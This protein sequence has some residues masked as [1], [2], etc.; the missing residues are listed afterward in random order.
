[1][2]YRLGLQLSVIQWLHFELYIVRSKGLMRVKISR[3]GARS[4]PELVLV[5]AMDSTKPQRL[6]LGQRT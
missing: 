4:V 1:M 5:A 6:R 3:E 2:Y